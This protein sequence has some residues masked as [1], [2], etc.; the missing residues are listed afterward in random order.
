VQVSIHQFGDNI[1]VVECIEAD[2]LQNITDGNNLGVDMRHQEA[3]LSQPQGEVE[4]DKLGTLTFSCF[5]NLSSLA[6]RKVLFVST[7]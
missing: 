6:S 3:Q 4:V 7:T 2:W 5:I 1:D